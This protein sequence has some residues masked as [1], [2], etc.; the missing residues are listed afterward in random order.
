[1]GL[2]EKIKETLSEAELYKTQGLLNEARDK[3]EQVSK[4]IENNDKI[5]NSESLLASIQKKINLLEKERT[6]VTKAPST[7]EMS[8]KAQNLIK[9]LF[10]FSHETDEG[11][12]ALEGAIS[13]AKFGQYKRALEEFDKLLTK[14][15]FRVSAAKN[16]IKCYN[17]FDSLE[18]AVEEFLKWKSSKTFT[19]VQIEKVQTF[20]EGLIKK[21]DK[22]FDLD[23]Q[24]SGSQE[25]IEFE[26]VEEE[27]DSAE[28]DEILDISSI[29]ITLD[30]G[31][32]KNT[33]IELDVSFQ[34]G[35]VISVIIAKTEKELIENLKINSKLDNVNFYSPIAIFRGAGI[36]KASTKID[37]GPK[38]GDFCLDIKITSI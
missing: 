4:L 31:A 23:G 2:K 7:P 26:E 33:E 22:T 10:T 27:E 28:I 1:M 17:E 3:Y 18:R 5:P 8:D 25:T 12:L 36:I 24:P 38:E 19:T 16:I 6:K 21:T 14:D 37:S 34:S 13:L 9:D 20:L 29:G 30:Q 15:N 11:T 32:S 35:N